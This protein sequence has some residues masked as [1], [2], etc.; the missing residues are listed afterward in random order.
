MLVG[1]RDYLS[2]LKTSLV[3]EISN[4]TDKTKLLILAFLQCGEIV[5]NYWVWSLAQIS[6]VCSFYR[7][8]FTWHCCLPMRVYCFYAFSKFHI[9]MIKNYSL[10]FQRTAPGSGWRWRSQSPLLRKCRSRKRWPPKVAQQMF[11]GL[12]VLN[13]WA[14]CKFKIRALK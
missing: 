13:F 14:V 4:G 7:H 1:K 3:F 12:S 10:C 2:Q 5:K 8:F 11:C 9:F 6:R